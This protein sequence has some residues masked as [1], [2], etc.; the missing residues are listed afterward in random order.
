MSAELKDRAIGAGAALSKDDSHAAKLSDEIISADFGLSKDDPLAKMDKRALRRHPCIDTLPI[1]EQNKLYER[2]GIIKYLLELRQKYGRIPNGERLAA[3]KELQL[4]WRR[5]HECMDEYVAYQQTYPDELPVNVF[6]PIPAGRPEGTGS[7]TDVHKRVIHYA[8]LQRARLTRYANGKLR[9]V[10]DYE[11]EVRD[12]YRFVLAICPNVGSYDKVRRYINRFRKEHPALFDY[13]TQGRDAVERDS[14]LKRKNDVTRPNQRWQSDVRYLPFYV[15]ENGEPCP[16]SLI[17]I[18]DDY[19]RYII[20]W[21]LIVSTKRDKDGRMVRNHAT[22]RDVCELLARAMHIW[23]IRPEEFYTDN[24]SEF[25]PLEDMLPKLADDPPIRFVRS[26]PRRPWGR[27]KVENGLGQVTALLRHIARGFRPKKDRP[28]IDIARKS[29]ELSITELEGEFEK[30]FNDVNTLTPK[31]GQSRAALWNGKAAYSAPPIRRLVHLN[32][33]HKRK[34]DLKVDHWSINWL[35]EEWE[36]RQIGVEEHDRNIYKRWAD[37]A[38]SDDEYLGWAIKL[39]TSWEAEVCLGGL[40]VDLA[41]KAP[42]AQDGKHNQ[43]QQA[44]LKD[45]GTAGR[46]LIAEGLETIKSLV[47]NVP[48]RR[49][50]DGEY[51]FVEPS[52]IA[53]NDQLSKKPPTKRGKSGK[54]APGSQDEAAKSGVATLPPETSTD[55]P[56]NLS[57]EPSQEEPSP[58]DDMAE[59]M[60]QL[61]E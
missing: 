45:I 22:A 21:K 34:E 32:I 1:D 5:V 8:L 49:T 7:L 36:P 13:F 10:R 31:K 39:D 17:I 52:P 11:F 53:Q 6:V 24:G 55:T 35:G 57:I 4:G 9:T 59:I 19:S 14:I 3:A 43:A 50:T 2:E 48:A 27:G 29:A 40:W 38:A 61:D 28:S 60:H 41:I 23:G 16:V 47:P 20:A 30:H 33:E 37:A 15:L 58:F 42:L 54:T 26:R 12:V 44:A 25:I 51:E 18:Y 46:L 56:M